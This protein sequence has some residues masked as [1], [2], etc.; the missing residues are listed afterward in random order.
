M[1]QE[2]KTQKQTW[3]MIQKGWGLGLAVPSLLVFCV[4]TQGQTLKFSKPQKLMSGT[5]KIVSP[6]SSTSRRS[7]AKPSKG[8]SKPQKLMSGM[9]KAVSP[10]SSTSRRSIAKP[11]KGNRS[12]VSS[13]PSTLGSRISRSSSIALPNTART[14]KELSVSRNNSVG[15]SS[16]RSVKPENNRGS[17]Q[18]SNHGAPPRVLSKQPEKP[19]PLPNFDRGSLG[20]RNP[21]PR[22]GNGVSIRPDVSRGIGGVRITSPGIQIPQRELP[23][24]ISNPIITLPNNRDPRVERMPIPDL[25]T[26]LP[27]R[28]E[29]MPNVVKPKP[30]LSITESNRKFEN[31]L[32][33][34]GKL[35]PK[36]L[37]IKDMG[38]EL[39]KLNLPTKDNLVLNMKRQEMVMGARKTMG[40]RFGIGAGCH[41]WLDLLCG[42][43][44]HRHGC[45]WTDLCAVP[46]Y[47]SCWR[48]CH[49]RVVWCPTMH[50]HVR[51]AWYFGIESF[52]IPDM[53]ALGVHE[54]SPYSPAAM[55]GL[56]AGDM[57]LSV[58]GYAFDNESVLPEMIQTSGGFLNLEVYREGLEA[59]MTV[60][61]RLRRLRITSH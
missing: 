1:T 21:F 56:K 38:K 52:L 2:K 46:G 22:L 6:S 48:P 55:A 17:G 39:N 32:G 28:T 57:I 54:V 47:W 7:I 29:G 40:L 23:P 53:H 27:E 3:G 5:T 13:K 4:T 51:S 31:I 43:H 41:W 49:Y 60:Q 10:S 26:S 50:G 37:D 14:D 20:Y 33:S 15:I 18:S 44:W 59:P 24:R 8:H 58:N 36:Q 11:S 34:V 19:K 16:S 12:S 9:T 35:K 61:V 30:S 42:W 25:G 45:H